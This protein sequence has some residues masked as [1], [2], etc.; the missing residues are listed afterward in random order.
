MILFPGIRISLFSSVGMCGSWDRNRNNDREEFPGEF[1]VSSQD[2]LFFYQPTGGNVCLTKDACNP[3][4]KFKA[5]GGWRNL[6]FP[7]TNTY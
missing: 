7:G 4:K 1:Q 6:V 5:Q 3:E 2:S